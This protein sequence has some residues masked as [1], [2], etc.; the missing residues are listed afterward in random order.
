MFIADAVAAPNDGKF[1][2]QGGGL[3]RITAPAFPY[4]VPQLGI[5]LRIELGD[6]EAGEPHA[7]EMSISDA[8]GQVIA[9]PMG[10]VTQSVPLNPLA[11]GEQRTVVIAAN[12]N[13][14][15]L[16]HAGA[17]RIDF[18]ADGETLGGT[19]FAAVDGA[20]TPQA[21]SETAMDEGAR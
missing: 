11:D 14:L 5:L 8:S 15:P 18:R 2:V 10:F 16:R 17:Y 7:F 19:T 6:D 9:P 12:V 21:D 13:G 4:N 1:Y 3:S 20:S